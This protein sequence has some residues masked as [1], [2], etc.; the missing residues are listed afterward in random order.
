[1]NSESTSN[2][3]KRTAD[4]LDSFMAYQEVGEGDP[5]VFL[6][7]N[8]MSSFLWR[9]IIPHVQ[10]LGRCI[11]PDLIGMGDSGRLASG[12]YRY[13]T[14]RAYL[15]SFC[16]ELDI[17]ERVVLVGHDWGGA[18]GFDWAQSHS[19]SV[20]GVAYGETLVHPTVGDEPAE[21]SELVKFCRSDE[22]EEAILFGDFLLDI[23]LRQSTLHPVAADVEQ[24][25]RRPW[26]EVG[27][28]RRPMLTWVQQV[29]TF[30]VPDDVYGVI[31]R[32]AA[33]M[34]STSVPK[35]LIV[36]TEGQLAGSHLEFCRTWPNQSEIT[37]EAKHFFQEDSAL[38]VGSALRRWIQGL[39]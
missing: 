33:W 27:E 14:H 9:N 29:P 11:A 5:I 26:L 2:Q 32:Y 20:R 24:E 17:R 4:V 18:L 6:H 28:G 16:E 19:D 22:G 8:P 31:D 35:L 30:G 7:G 38:M 13:A 37:V 3:A 15:E 21:R 36:S 23:F 10:D 12:D 25:Y 34:A 1:M 39:D